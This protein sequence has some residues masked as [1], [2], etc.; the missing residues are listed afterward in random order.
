MRTT[1]SASRLVLLALLALSAPMVAFTGMGPLSERDEAIHAEVAREILTTGDWVTLHFGGQAWFDKPPLVFWMSAA[2][3]RVLG[4]SEGAARLPVA[5]CGLLLVLTIWALA[6]AMY[7]DEAGLM[8]AV[9]AAS[10]PMLAGAA[11]IVLMDVPLTLFLT[12]TLALF[13]LSTSL[14]S[15]RAIA[16]ASACA[17]AAMGLGV[18]TKGPVALALP[19]FAVILAM[20]L[21]RDLRPRW[22]GAL[23]TAF[24][25]CVLVSLPWYLLATQRNGAAFVDSFIGFHNVGR[26]MR[27]EHKNGASALLYVG[28]LIAGFLPWTPAMLCGVLQAAKRRTREDVLLLVWSVVILG[29]FGVARTK[30]AAYILPAFPALAILAARRLAVVA[31]RCRYGLVLQVA[32]G[33]LLAALALAAVLALRPA[34][35]LVAVA[36][37]ATASVA[38][39]L[40]GNETYRLRL[41]VM[42]FVGCLLAFVLHAAV[43]PDVREQTGLR[44]AVLAASK[45]DGPLEVCGASMPGSAL[46]YSQGRAKLIQSASLGHPGDV[47]LMRT[48]DVAEANSA[49]VCWRGRRWSVVRIP[50]T[51]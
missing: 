31:D 16:L 12:V 6:R 19:G 27:S 25:V 39:V 48:S 22:V 11:G 23:P 30:L 28:V 38:I 7:G 15:R 35:A 18:L 50:S 36:W 14:D 20:V 33:L 42:V 13:Y 34:D 10:A 26:F 49:T 2:S 43:V 32:G 24:A 8:A 44:S 9:I 41:R 45:L 17:G 51:H 5:V 3:M 29:F 21:R 46:F 37:L 47:L 40:F 4:V 1:G